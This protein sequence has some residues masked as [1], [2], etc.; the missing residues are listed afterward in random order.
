LPALI[1]ELKVKNNPDYY[2]E[3]QIGKSTFGRYSPRALE[4]L[5]GAIE[6]GQLTP[7]WE[8][9]RD[10]LRLKKQTDKL[11]FRSSHARPQ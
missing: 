8:K 10:S 5:R 6:A 11:H 7:A 2:K 1:V 9:Y 4:A 3:I